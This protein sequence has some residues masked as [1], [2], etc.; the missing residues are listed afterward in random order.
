MSTPG[1][2]PR[3][4]TRRRSLPALQKE[5]GYANALAGAAA[6]EDRA[7]HG[8]RRGDRRTPKLLESAV[9]ELA[10]ITGQKPVV[11]KARKAIANFK[12]REGQPIGCMVTLRGERM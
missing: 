2:P 1:P 3:R 6:R 5:I 10:A 8:P 11:R 4:A 7:Q 12:L 9:E